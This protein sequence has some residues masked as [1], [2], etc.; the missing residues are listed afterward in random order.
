M[1]RYKGKPVKAL[2]VSLLQEKKGA[3]KEVWRILKIQVKPGREIFQG[4]LNKKKPPSGAG[5][6][7]KKKITKNESSCR[8]YDSFSELYEEGGLSTMRKERAS[9]KRKEI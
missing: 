4:G 3:Q 8:R 1:R 7:W 9:K 2:R 6:P 5:I